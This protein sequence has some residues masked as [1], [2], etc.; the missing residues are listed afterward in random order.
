MELY[1]LNAEQSVLGGLLIDEKAIIQAIDLKSE[2]FY[3]SAHSLIYEAICELH[4]KNIP[5]DI[6]TVSDHLKNKNQLS[7]IGG[8]AYINDLALSVIST[9][10]LT[11]YVDIVNNNYILR[12]LNKVAYELTEIIKNDKDKDK[13]IEFVQNSIYNVVSRSNEGTKT[14]NLAEIAAETYASIADKFS[15]PQNHPS[16]A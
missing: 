5:P 4:K 16:A 2:S 7:H 14:S 9:A 15:N 6:T 11:H 1:N 12:E 8:R 10:N 3:K 13:A